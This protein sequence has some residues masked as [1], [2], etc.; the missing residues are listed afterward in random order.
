MT[1]PQPSNQELPF[2]A[3]LYTVFLCII[4]GSNAVAVKMAFAGV[5]VFT[6]ATLRFAIATIA[7]FLWIRVTGQPLRVGKGQMRRLLVFSALF[8]LQLSLFYL[9]LSKSNASRG[10]L[11]NNLLPFFVLFLAHFFIPGDRITRRKLAG[12][13][14]GF[15]GVAFLFGDR[16]GIGDGFL[17]GDLIILAGTLVW[18]CSAV[19]LKLIIADFRPIH[20]V[21]YQ[22]AFAVPLFFLAALLWDQ[23]MISDLSPAVIGAL[24]F[25]SLI[26]AAYGFVAWNTLLQKYGAVSLHSFIF[27]MPI[28][29]VIFG[30]LILEEPITLK[31][32][33]AMVF[34]V[35]GILVVQWRSGPAVRPIR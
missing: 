15:G 21:L 8:T 32:M 4:F 22:M 33:L 28:A 24:L 27:I 13:L 18:A 30:G 17:A 11:I 14:L 31:I 20:L 7:L 16:G 25:Q 23:P 2:A 10:T 26:S 6:S 5:G 34:I 12:I 9:G 35:A 1:G 29:G 3:I 19:Y